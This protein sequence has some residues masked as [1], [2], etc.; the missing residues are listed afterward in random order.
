MLLSGVLGF[1]SWF[2]LLWALWKTWMLPLVF[3][4]NE[5]LECVGKFSQHH[6]SPA[7]FNKPSDFTCLFILAP[8]AHKGNCPRVALLQQLVTGMQRSIWPL[9]LIPDGEDEV[10]GEMTVHFLPSGSRSNRS[11]NR[12]LWKWQTKQYL[13]IWVLYSTAQGMKKHTWRL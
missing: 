10:S 3:C 11:P 5:S 12:N 2:V 9:T 7:L 6:A 1:L 8:S 4:V 13:W